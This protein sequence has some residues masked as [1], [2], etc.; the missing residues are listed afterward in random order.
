MKDSESIDDFLGR[1]SGLATK[2]AALGSSIDETRPVR[3]FF[4]GMPKRFI[5]IVAS[6]EQMIDLKTLK[7]EKIVGRL[8][9]FEDRVNSVD[10]ETESHGK[11]LFNRA[12]AGKLKGRVKE[13]YE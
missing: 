1:A 7:F 9:A 13:K 2:F 6:I 4:A 11:L 12:K 8:N 5:N 10:D 3:K